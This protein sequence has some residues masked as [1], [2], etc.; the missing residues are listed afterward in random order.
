MQSEGVSYFMC[1]YFKGKSSAHYRG[2]ASFAVG[3]PVISLTCTVKDG[4]VNILDLVEH[5][6][7]LIGNERGVIIGIG[8]SPVY[9]MHYRL[10]LVVGFDAEGYLPVTMCFHLFSVEGLNPENLIFHPLNHF[11]AMCAIIG[12]QVDQPYRARFADIPYRARF[13][14]I[15]ILSNG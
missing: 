8:V 6:R 15:Q 13:A 12:Q 4:D 5:S 10:A 3:T 2:S 1:H 14:D 11:S 7:H 9:V